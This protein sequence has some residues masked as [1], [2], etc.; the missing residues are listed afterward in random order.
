MP[1]SGRNEKL[2]VLEEVGVVKEFD[3]EPGVQGTDPPETQSHVGI[4]GSQWHRVVVG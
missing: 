3:D 4:R 2:G 1:K